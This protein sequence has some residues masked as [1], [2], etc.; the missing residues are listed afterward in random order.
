MTLETIS[1]T[2]KAIVK[3]AD[4]PPTSTS[5]RTVRCDVRYF[6]QVRII[7][8]LLPGTFLDISFTQNK[9]HKPLHKFLRPEEES[10]SPS[11]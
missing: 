1:L 2:V 11:P 9:I 4:S 6:S 3:P 5:L 10:F 7:Y 8:Q